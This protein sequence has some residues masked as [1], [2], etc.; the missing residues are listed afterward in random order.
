MKDYIVRAT[1][2]NNTIRA[3]AA[4]TSQMVQEAHNIHDTSGVASAALG[5]TMTAAVLMSQMLKG[6]NDILT[7]QIKADGP[8]GGIVVIADSKANIRGY[9]SNPHV[10]IPLNSNG[11]LDVSSAVGKN[12]YLNVIK[13]L[14]MK[15]PYIGYVDLTS[16]EIGEDIAYYY[17]FSEQVPSIVSLGVQIAPDESVIN[18]GG[19]IIQ[20]MPGADD[21]IIDFLENKAKSIPSITQLLS[22][23]KTPEDILELF[24]G[25]KDLVINDKT[26]TSY[27]CNCSKER[28][29]RNLISL[30]KKEIMEIVE[31]QHEAE[32]QCH[33]CNTKYFFTED[34]LLR[35]LKDGEIK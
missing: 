11:K 22:E 20:L 5:R 29:E 33:F 15:S 13:D 17:A 8:L 32:L 31:E 6:D 25:E 16:G 10:Y 1:A 26:Q 19:Y 7:I 3:F 35:L 18:S 9:V 30:G 12:G 28:M 4:V 21:G 2:A 24:L 14:G 34:E 23:G 27:T